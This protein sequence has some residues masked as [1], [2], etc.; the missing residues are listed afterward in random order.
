MPSKNSPKS[1]KILVI[2]DDVVTRKLLG[3]A[4]LARGHAVTQVCGLTQAGEAIAAEIF[5]ASIVDLNMPDGN[6][7]EFVHLVRRGLQSR[8]PTMTIAVCSA[9][10]APRPSALL[11]RL[12]ADAVFEKPVPLDALCALIETGNQRQ[13]A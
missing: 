5:D 10:A 6:G 9:Y 3:A 8:N 7:M 1:L 12:G 4:L 13:A 11:K 2:D